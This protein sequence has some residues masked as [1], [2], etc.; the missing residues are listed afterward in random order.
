MSCHCLCVDSVCVL[1][2]TDM[3]ELESQL[4]EASD[5]RIK[6]IVSDGIFSM[7]GSIVPLK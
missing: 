1:L 3:K 2:C 7:D 6:I 5:A 4:K